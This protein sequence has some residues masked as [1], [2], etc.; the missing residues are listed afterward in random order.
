MLRSTGEGHPLTAMSKYE[1]VTGVLR[2]QKCSQGGTRGSLCSQ[3]PEP[4]AP[5]HSS[6]K[7]AQQVSR[8]RAPRTLVG[9]VS[10]ASRTSSPP[11]TL[12]PPHMGRGRGWAEPFPPIERGSR[13]FCP[14]QAAP[15][16][17]S[18]RRLPPA[19]VVPLRSAHADFLSSLPRGTWAAVA[20]LPLSSDNWA[21]SARKPPSPLTKPLHPVSGLDGGYFQLRNG[22]IGTL[23]TVQQDLRAAVSQQR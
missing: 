22:L 18:L 2:E 6:S 20:P 5:R 12:L 3:T 14:D 4:A 23:A 17:G 21:R 11:C 1:A 9:Q 19:S 10:G 7:K 8:S 13:V 16:F 15:G